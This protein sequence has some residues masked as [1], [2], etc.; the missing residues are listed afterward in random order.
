MGDA[1][2][3][4]SRGSSRLANESGSVIL[5]VALSSVC[6][7][8]MLGLALDVGYMYHHRRVMQSAADAGAIAGGAEIE[9]GQLTGVVQSEAR[10]G[11]ARHGFT[12][13]TDGVVVTVHHPPVSGFYVGNN[14]FVEV[15]IEQPLPIFVMRL[16]GYTNMRI[17]ARA[18]AG[19][20]GD[21]KA[22]VY[23]LDPNREASFQANSSAT[24][25]AACGI[26]V[27]S[28]HSNAMDLNS[29]THIT[30]N[31]IAIN[32]G[33]ST[34]SSATVTPTPTSNLGI[35]ERRPVGLAGAAELYDSVHV[36]VGVSQLQGIQQYG[37]DPESWRVLRRALA[38]GKLRCH[39]Q[40]GDLRSRRRAGFVF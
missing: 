6:L 31:S 17:P 27:D 36:S 3:R 2:L 11:T 12:D 30:A 40:S 25:N 29:S 19:V 23:V 10:V 4:V 13:G 7:L 8:G 18:V 39:L 1:M 9:R 28:N 15:L 37:G 20:G 34:E 22:C 5:I 14:K 38:R 33:Y 24:V 21:A 32:G 35:P 16:F 26:I